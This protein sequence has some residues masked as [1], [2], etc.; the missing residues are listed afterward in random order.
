[1]NC[2]LCSRDEPALKGGEDT[3]RV[4]FLTYEPT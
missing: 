4:I 3:G 2:A 1:M